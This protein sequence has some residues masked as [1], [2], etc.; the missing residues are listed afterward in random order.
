MDVV[1]RSLTG[2]LCFVLIDDVLVFAD[3]IEEHAH[4][5]VKVLQRFEKANLLL[6]PEKC[7]FELQQ[8]NYLGYFVSRD[9]VIA[10]PN[11]VKSV[12]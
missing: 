8:V 12:R 4:Q 5:L 7:A 9:G 6:Q 3:T 1:L 11:K 10:S 2:E